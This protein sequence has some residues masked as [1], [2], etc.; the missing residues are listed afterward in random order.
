MRDEAIDFRLVGYFSK[1]PKS[2]KKC[3]KT[4]SKTTSIAHT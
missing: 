4:L 3:L 1:I 2:H